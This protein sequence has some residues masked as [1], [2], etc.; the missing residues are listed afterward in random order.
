MTTASDKWVRDVGEADFE[1][2][3]LE[4]SKARPVVVDFWAPWCPPCVKLSPLLERLVNERNGEVI[5]AKIN[6]DDAPG[7]AGSFRIASIPTVIAFR[8]GQAVAEFQ[9]LL[10]E[11]QLR[12]FLDRIGP[13][14]ADRLSTNARELESSDPQEAE[15]LYRQAIEKDRGNEAAIL[16]LAR[17]LVQRG[18]DDEVQKLIENTGF[19]GERAEE[20]DRLAALIYLHKLARELP[21]EKATRQS[22]EAEAKSGQRQYELGCVL[23]AAGKYQEALDT[24]LAAA[25]LDPKL[26]STKVREAMVQIFYV[27]GARSKL[28]DEY[29]NRLSTLLY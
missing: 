21:D 2:E 23:A 10:P 8:D 29:R 9:G 11:S 26:A 12:T 14:E 27:V 19:Q 6:V 5:L 20:A 3:V 15:A 1:R 17:I 16:G 25:E 22:V 13:S 24:L 28:A 18:Q 7:L 4:G